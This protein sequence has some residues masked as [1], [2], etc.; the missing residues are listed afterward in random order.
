MIFEVAGNET[1]QGTSDVRKGMEIDV[2][3]LESYLKKNVHNKNVNTNKL[4]INPPLKLKQFSLGQ[5]NPT[6]FIEDSNKNKYVLRK[7]PAGKLI[8][9]T[10]H[11]VEREFRVL[12][13]VAKSTKVKVP[14]VYLLCT[15]VKVIG[16][17]FYI[18]DFVKGRIFSDSLLKSISDVNHKH[19]IY[20]NA[21]DTLAELHRAD[22]IKNGMAN[23]LFGINENDKVQLNPQ[24]LGNFYPRQIERLSQV[25]KAQSIVQDKNGNQVNQ[26]NN[27]DDIIYYLKANLPKDEIS[28]CHGDYKLDNIIYDENSSNVIGVLD[29]ELCTIGHPL[30]DLANFLL[31]FYCTGSEFSDIMRLMDKPRPLGIPE[32]EDLIKYYCKKSNRI[33]PIP[34]WDFCVAFSYFRLAI[35]S[36]GIAARLKLGQASSANAQQAASMFQFCARRIIEI[37]NHGLNWHNPNS[38]NNKISKY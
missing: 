10:A 30:S 1:G 3:A 13:T 22:P 7:K 34:N 8:S 9:K 31:P 5:S 37:K 23:S 27:Y 15:D 16:T 29:W 36:Q 11:N 32:A 18:M 35:I 26:L 12:S 19:Q 2:N 38:F 17:S 33:Y 25:S 6:Y 20:Y 24:K 21:M 14:R 4:I 28:F